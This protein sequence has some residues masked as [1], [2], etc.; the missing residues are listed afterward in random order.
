LNFLNHAPGI[1]SGGFLYAISDLYFGE[2]DLVTDTIDYIA[3]DQNGLTSTTTR[4][5]IVEAPSI[6]PSDDA[7]STPPSSDDAGTTT[8]ATSTSS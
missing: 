5:V 3:T 6:V 2:T 7:S 1:T 8:S 4:T